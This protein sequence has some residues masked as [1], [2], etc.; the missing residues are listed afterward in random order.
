MSQA[1]QILVAHFNYIAGI[2]EEDIVPAQAQ[3]VAHPRLTSEAIETPIEQL[4]LSVRVF[5]ALKRAG[6]STVG[7]V[8]ELLN[9]G[10]NAVMSI[11]NFGEKSL[12]EL[13]QK[14][15]EKGFLPED[16]EQS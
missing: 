7:D 6:I 4:E 9:K 8:L 5:N 11:R 13:K 2:R 10:E 16:E 12:E 1:A 14:M 15:R 3:A